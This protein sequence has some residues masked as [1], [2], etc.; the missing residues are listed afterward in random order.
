MRILF[1]I[2]ENLSEIVDEILHSEKWISIV[3]KDQKGRKYVEIK[4]PIFSSVAVAEIGPE[5]ILIHTAWSK[6]SYRIFQKDGSIWCEYVGAYRGLL[7]QQLLPKFSPTENLLDVDVF[8]ST[9]YG[10][11]TRKLRDYANDNLMLKEFRRRHFLEDRNGTARFDHPQ[12]VYDEFIK[13][14]Y[15]APKNPEEK[16]MK[17]EK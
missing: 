9:L 5:S 3:K 13:E 4:D 8:E 6:Y 11:E 12:R 14:D 2:K 10:K 15:I 1:K 17:S 16:K 7:Q